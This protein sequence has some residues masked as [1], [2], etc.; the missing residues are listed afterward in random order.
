MTLHLKLPSQILKAQTEVIKEKN[1]KA[2]NLQGMDKA[3]KVRPDGTRCI[4]N[5]SWLPL[6]GNLRDLIMHESHKSKYSIHPGSDKMYQD[7]K[8]LYWW[9]NMKAIIAEYVGKCLTCSRVKAEC[10]KPSG[11]LIQPEIPTW[12]WE[13]ITMDFVTKLPKTSSGHDTIW[14]IVDRLTKSAHFIPTKA[15]DSMET[16]TRLYI[17]EIVSRHGVPISI[18]SDRD[19]HFT[20]RFWQSI[21]T[22]LGTQLDMR[23]K[24]SLDR[25]TK[26]K[27]PNQT[28]LRDMPLARVIDFRKGCGET[29]PLDALV[30]SGNN[31]KLVTTGKANY[32]PY[33]IDF[34]QGQLLGFPNFIPPYALATDQHISTGVNYGSAYAG[35]RE[36]TGR[37]EGDRFTF[38]MQLQNHEAV[39]SR[40]S[41]LQQNN[42][43]TQDYL[44]ECIYL[45]NIGSDDYVNNYLMPNN[46][47]T[48]HIYTTGQYAAVLSQRYSQ[49]LT[50]LYNLGARKIAVY[51]LGLIGCALT[52]IT[53]FGTDGKTCV[54]SI[55]NDVGLFNDRLKP[56]V[57][58]LNIDFS[59]ARFTFINLTNIQATQGGEVLP[60]VA[61]CQVRPSDA[62]S[63]SALSA[64]DASPYDI[65]HLARL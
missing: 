50:T 39:I 30:D 60:N 46:Y 2:E 51:G 37:T 17:K 54:E 6:F 4:K 45:V 64:M 42:T 25:W 29:L 22:C 32:L 63:Y 52:K 62:Q 28:P 61:C 21:M 43:F 49:Q 26:V 5:R 12:K 31:N 18:I 1:I 7:L 35:I 16:L 15:T 23:D 36:E 55:N 20:S 14:V 27:E 41:R 48:S 53:R 38:D 19:S 3:F 8:K 56:V 59:Y 11:L 40:L 24:S 57:D 34:P 10:Q 65:S 47:P 58:M 9:P 33:G 13:R 44:K